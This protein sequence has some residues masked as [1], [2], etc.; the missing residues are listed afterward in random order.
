[1][2]S[3]DTELERCRIEIQKLNQEPHNQIFRNEQQLLLMNDLKDLEDSIMYIEKIVRHLSTTNDR[4]SKDMINKI[5][6]LIQRLTTAVSNF[7]RNYE[8]KN[9]SG[10]VI[11]MNDV[12][13]QFKSIVIDRLNRRLKI[14]WGLM[15]VIG[16]IF[17]I[18]II[19]LVICVFLISPII[20]VI[21][22]ILLVILIILMSY[23]YNSIKTN[24]FL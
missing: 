3:L 11:G 9:I 16:F 22:L 23:Q 4:L 18:I 14:N 17:L 7:T 19:L 6:I 8:S 2:S 20:G 24:L 10:L 15:W 12:I 13:S 5:T 21:I 1:M